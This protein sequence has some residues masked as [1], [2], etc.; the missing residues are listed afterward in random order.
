MESALRAVFMFVLFIWA[1]FPSPAW[2][3]LADG[4]FDVGSWHGSAVNADGSFAFCSMFGLFGRNTAPLAL[5]IALNDSRGWTLAIS[6]D[7]LKLPVGPIKARLAFDDE[8]PSEIRGEIRSPTVIAFS[9]GTTDLLDR[10]SGAGKL[11]LTFHELAL[12]FD[13]PQFAAA[14]GSL[15]DCLRLHAATTVVFQPLTEMQILAPAPVQTIFIM[16]VQVREGLGLRVRL[17]GL[18]AISCLASPFLLLLAVTLSFATWHLR[19]RSRYLSLWRAEY[20]GQSLSPSHF[21]LT[22]PQLL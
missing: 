4:S 21:R 19:M 18:V 11:V 12:P 6:S 1:F 5:A 22:H 17:I 13:L 10:H 3:E 14:L 9:F 8:P 2:A 20:R 15:R 16:P 7:R